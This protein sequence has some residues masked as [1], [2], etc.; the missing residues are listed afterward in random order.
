MILKCTFPDCTFA[1]EDHE[2][3]AAVG[4]LNNHTQYHQQQQQQQQQVSA[5][6][7]RSDQQTPRGPKLTRPVVK[8]S[9][10]NEE[11]NAFTRRWAHYRTGCNISDTDATTQLLECASEDLGDLVL[12][13]HPQF[14]SKPINEAI[15]LLKSF[16]VVPVALG[17]LRSELLAIHQDADEPFRKFSARV[18]GKAE[19]CEFMTTYHGKCTGCN[20]D[21]S[22]LTYYTNE[23]IRDVLLDGIADVDIRREAQSVEG[24]LNKSINE[25]I[26]FVE[27]RETARNANQPSGL[28]AVSNYRRQEKRVTP[29]PKRNPSPSAA[30][31]AK[32]ANCPDCNAQFHLFT[33]KS[34][35]WNKNPH[36]RC[37]EC[38]KRARNNQQRGDAQNNTISV[39]SESEQ[40]GQISAL[41][42]PSPAPTS[43]NKK[44]KRRR[45]RSG[46]HKSSG[47][48]T[49]VDTNQTT[50]D[51]VSTVTTNNVPLMASPTNNGDSTPNRARRRRRGNRRRRR[52]PTVAVLSHHVFTKAGWR[53]TR[54][55]SHPKVALSIS[56][57]QRPSSTFKIDGL[58]DSGA[59]VDVWSMTEYLKAGFRPEDLQSVSMSL[60]AANESPISI[61][62]AFFATITGIK[63]DN[64][65]IK[66]NSMVYVSKAVR[67]F[68]LSEATMMD[69]GMLSR[70]FP[71]PGCALDGSTTVAPDNTN[72]DDEPPQMQSASLRAM[73]GG[74]SSRR[75]PSNASCD[76]PHR[77]SVPD[78]PTALPFPC[79]PENNDKMRQW[80]LKRYSSST[81]NTCPHRPIPCMSGP[82]MEIHVDPNAEPFARHKARPINVH[83]EK[84]VYDELLRDE[85]LDVIE[86]PPIGEPIT[87]CHPMTITRKHDGSPRR[88]VDLSR[89]NKHCTRETHSSESPFHV[90]RRIPP[91]TWK[92]VTD[93][94]NGFHSIPLRES[95]RYLTTFITPFGLWRYKRAVQGFLS[96]GD[97]FNRRFDAILSDFERKERVVDD[98]IHYDTDLEAH[99]WRTIDLLT[100]TGQSGIVLNP[101]KFQFAKREVDFAGF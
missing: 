40:F 54:L 26:G 59:Q 100:I 44:K 76:C 22:G 53:R 65:P 2:T 31:K 3:S 62:G 84:Q 87:W 7:S 21:Y 77:E 51:L 48:Q 20:A 93:A 17:V 85:A 12:R 15:K 41:S 6:T 16:A 5:P 50:E 83:W 18:Q 29:A 39:R 89:L 75:S 23:M 81:F 82:P 45:R 63:A 68:Y 91:Q 4:L 88:T 80:L 99:W 90:A 55:R 69:L 52:K 28:A 67:G 34:R 10:T 73:D 14:T 38:W 36:E 13:A 24:M 58:A 66:C 25:I 9:I 46:Q 42:I 43:N 101:D 35:G 71:T 97:G 74:C 32:T 98:T 70:N 57:E 1:T 96:S 95:D 8:S 27:S 37:Q 60:N 61:D 64:T 49:E 94:W 30:D 72:I 11:W 19:V 56:P 78:R 79:T 33:N 92:T 86:R 47:P